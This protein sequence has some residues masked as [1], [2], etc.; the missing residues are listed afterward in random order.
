MDIKY[1]VDTKLRSNSSNDLIKLC[2][3]VA[4]EEHSIIIFLFHSIRIEFFFVSLNQSILPTSLH[5]SLP[6]CHNQISN[7]VVFQSRDLLNK[8]FYFPYKYQVVSVTRLW[9][10]HMC[11]SWC[12]H[13]VCSFSISFCFSLWHSVNAQYARILT[14]ECTLRYNSSDR[15]R[16]ICCWHNVKQSI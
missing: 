1:G 16:N 5:S 15:L 4:E 12:M 11:V 7:F 9:V 8:C 6:V 2:I 13:A 3:T 14:L 10:S